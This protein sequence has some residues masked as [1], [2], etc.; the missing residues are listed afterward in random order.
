MRKSFTA[1]LVLAA[2]LI[3]AIPSDAAPRNRQ[4]VSMRERNVAA[5]TRLIRMVKR[6]F[7][8]ESNIEPTVPIPGPSEQAPQRPSPTEP[9]PTPEEP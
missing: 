5:V 7:G 4:D 1:S 3:V 2:T 9:T 8:V 6:M